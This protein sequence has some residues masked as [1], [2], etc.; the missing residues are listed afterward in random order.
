MKSKLSVLLCLLLV[1]GS[2]QSARELHYFKQGDNY[3]RLNIKEDAFL[4]SSRYT[5]GYFDD[6][7]VD[8]YFGEIARPDSAKLNKAPKME[9]VTDTG[10]ESLDNKKLVLLLSTNAQAVTDQ[11]S[12][13]AENEEALG[14][15]ARL[16]NKDLIDRNL[17]LKN[18]IKLQ[19]STLNSIIQSGETYL[20]AGAITVAN[21]ASYLLAFINSVAIARG[22]KGVFS[23]LVEAKKWFDEEF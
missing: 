6:N 21:S 10:L 5:A 7:A 22:R 23:D 11:I 20:D 18:E 12:A 17:E 3:Y 14:M 19:K 1:A 9:K 4:S 8:R 15:I 13:F 2:C 16:A